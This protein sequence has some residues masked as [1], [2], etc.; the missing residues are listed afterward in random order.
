M[1][2]NELEQERGITILS[3][4]T[5][6]SYKGYKINIV[7][8]PG[9][10]DFGGEVERIMNMV[11][12]VC[13]VVCAIE[14]PMPQTRFVLRKALERG[15]KPI[16]V[17]NKADR[18]P[19]RVGEVEN[20]IL[21][22]F[23]S[24]NA[25]DEQLDYQLVYASA[26]AGWAVKDYNNPDK[27][28]VKDLLDT[29]IERT[30]I[31]HGDINKDFTMLVS[32]I[33]SNK[34]YGK[35]LIGRIHNGIIK[36]GDKINALD[37]K[38]NFV[39]AAKVHKIIRRL[40]TMQL[41]LQQAGA[42]DIVSISGFEKGTVT[43]TLNTDKTNIVIPSIPID[44]PM[45]SVTAITN[46]SPFFG[47]DG[48]KITFLQLK[49]RFLREQENDV[50]L[51]VEFD[52]KKGDSIFVYGRGDLHLGILIEKMRREGFEMALTP[53]QVIFKEENKVKLEPIE[54]VTIEI[55]LDHVNELIDSIQNRK[56]I[57]I[58]TDELA[59][60]KTRIVFEAP[61]RGLFGFRPYLI[62]LTKGTVIIVSKFKGYEKYRGPLKRITRGAL[63]SMATGKCT[64]YALKDCEN[65]GPL[66]VY[67]G[68]EVYPGMVIGELT[69]EGE[70]E[71]NACREK[72]T[73]NVRAANKDEFFRMSPH[74]SFSLEEALVMLRP[75]ELLECTPKALRIRKRVLDS[76][77]RR[78]TAKSSKKEEEI[79]EF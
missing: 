31:P 35:M 25:T 41:E 44:P 27:T 3:K 18:T 47:K 78:T 58:G 49:E 52:V 23:C 42:G 57:V 69:K 10:Q 62:T 75:D 2:S 7:D 36:I 11:D 70:I 8:T 6:I 38:G 34:F 30:P 14:G 26:R 76:K 16:V 33:E 39:E 66:Y 61:S 65:K 51:R 40:G 67:P 60:G 24:L 12:A 28:S 20:E 22:L 59:N 37:L 72:P 17:I 32:Q 1:D 74:K 46:D 79:Y 73:T 56:G 54:E 71:V 55:D 48:D 5:G 29:I 15:L 63:L 68:V 64:I 53:P 77:L 50:S 45:I 9:H 19:N 13:L 21:D 4:C 43:H